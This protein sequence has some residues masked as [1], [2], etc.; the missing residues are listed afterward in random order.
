MRDFLFIRHAETDMAGRFCGHSDP[1]L[2]E[3][4]RQRLAGL[5]DMLSAYEIR[6]VFTSDLR[7]AHQTA[8]AIGQ[9]FGAE[10]R[11][12]SGLREIQFGLWEGL[13][14]SEIEMRDP[15]L[16]RRWVEE[17]PKS[18]APNGEPFQ[19]FVS[20]V[21]KEVSLLQEEATKLP[22][23]VV[24]HAGVIRVALT[25]W[26]GMSEQEAWDRTRCY[27]SVVALDKNLIHRTATEVSSLLTPKI[28]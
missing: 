20:R 10:P 16:A 24:T 8:D 25:T 28:C 19:Q 1:E 17:Y 7:R 2:N 26:F 21:R 22:I 18:T 6:E 11:V 14:W 3:R 23:A 13:S 9:H 15:L 5:V 4:G 27:G 12:R